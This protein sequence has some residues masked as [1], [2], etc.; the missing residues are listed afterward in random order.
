MVNISSEQ[1]LQRRIPNP[2][3]SDPIFGRFFGDPD[4]YGQPSRREL[5]LGS[6]VIVSSDGYIVTNN[7]VVSRT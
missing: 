2:F 5:S 1:V 4:L 7:H 6:G 3:E